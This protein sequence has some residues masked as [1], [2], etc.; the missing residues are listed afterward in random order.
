MLSWV[1]GS[2]AAHEAEQFSWNDHVVIPVKVTGGA[3]C[4]KF[5]VPDKIFE[6]RFWVH[7][8]IITNVLVYYLDISPVKFCHYDFM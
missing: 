7:N 1:G 6:V 2:G 3:A 5:N 8:Q 4:G